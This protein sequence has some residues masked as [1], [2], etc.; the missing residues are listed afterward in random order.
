MVIK[1]A[2]LHG[3]AGGGY[4]LETIDTSGDTD[5]VHLEAQD[6]NEAMTMAREYLEDEEFPVKDLTYG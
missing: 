2:Y 4:L 6:S 3:D 1:S 5:L